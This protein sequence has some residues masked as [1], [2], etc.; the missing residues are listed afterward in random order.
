MEDK[1]LLSLKEAAEMLGIHYTT[2]RQYVR[3]GKFPVVRIGRLLKIEA[4]DIEDYIKNN[5][6]ILVEKIK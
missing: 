1:K 3:R 4:K 2:M 6:T 5:K